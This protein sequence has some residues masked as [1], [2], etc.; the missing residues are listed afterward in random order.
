MM[1]SNKLWKLVSDDLQVS[2]SEGSFSSF[3]KPMGVLG[4]RKSGSSKVMVDLACPSSFHQKIIEQRFYNQ[5]QEAFVR[6]LD[7]KTEISF[8]IDPS[9]ASA[10]KSS[11]KK[12]AGPLFDQVKRREL[13]W[14]SKITNIGLRED[15]VFDTFAVSTSNE[16]AHAAAMAVSRQFGRSYNPLFLHGGVGVGKTHLMQAIAIDVL[17]KKPNIKL[18]YS[19]GEQFTNEIIEAIQQKKTPA[20][21]QRYRKVEGLLIDDI[22]F[23]AGKTYVQEEFFHTF[24]AIL[25]AG[26]QVVM[27]SDRP[28]GEIK[29][30][31][32]RL[33]SRFEAGLI[34]DIGEPSFELRTAIVLIKA[35]QR[36][37]SIDMETAQLIAANIESARKIEG[38]LVRVQT[39]SQLKNTS[40]TPSM[41]ESLLGKSAQ[42]SSTP[43]P[44]RPLE[45][46]RGVAKY[47]NMTPRQIRGS[48]RSRVMVTPRHVA[49]YLLRMDYKLPYEEI[50]S[51]FSNRDHST[52]MHAV[53]KITHDLRSSDSLRVDV[54]E[55]RNHL[56]E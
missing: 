28:P 8:T 14:Q 53:D 32:D 47:Y 25:Q 6:A 44:L 7:A 2:L 54:G 36:N 55:V 34:V 40:A 37:L 48:G 21:R 33:K 45:I 17:K 5:I 12:D 56:Y 38:F 31:E 52:V 50:G 10:G 39:E 26:G 27:T 49:M 23:I 20:F 30:L 51:Y 46:I 9:L 41:I 13:G 29:A 3:I 4:L 11:L 43:P 22:Q 24:N 35:E 19:M 42:A 1:D 15:Y 16:V 18:M